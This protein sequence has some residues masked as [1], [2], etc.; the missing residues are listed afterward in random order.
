MV[1]VA[2]ANISQE[3]NFTELGTKL[4]SLNLTFNFTANLRVSDDSI[5]NTFN[6]SQVII[7]KDMKCDEA[8]TLLTRRVADSISGGNLLLGGAQLTITSLL[9]IAGST[10]PTLLYL[11]NLMQDIYLFT[12]IGL[13]FPF[14]TRTIL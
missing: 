7:L 6:S 8:K 12:F 14:Y 2:L 4:T 13:R 3:L 9:S 10:Q 1:E 5:I 11:L